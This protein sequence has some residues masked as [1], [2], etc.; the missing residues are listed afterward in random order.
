MIKEAMKKILSWFLSGVLI[1]SGFFVVLEKPVR[2]EW[3]NYVVISEF[4]TRGSTSAYDEFV[5]LYN[6]TENIVDISGWK[7]QY[8]GGSTWTTKLTI[9]SG[10]KI[11]PHRYYLMSSSSQYFT[12]TV[13]DLTH[14]SY[15]ALA[16]GTAGDPRGIRIITADNM[17]I[18][19][20]IYEADGGTDN[21]LAEG[22]KTAPAPNYRAN[23]YNRS[24]ERKPGGESGNGQDTNIN[25]HDFFVRD[26]RDPTNSQALPRPPIEQPPSSQPQCG[27]GT[28]ETGESSE[29]C[30]QDCQLNQPVCGNNLKE[31]KEECDKTDLAGQ[32]CMTLGF[33]SGTLSCNNNCTFN[34]SQCTS[35]GSYPPPIVEQVKPGDIA[36]NE[37]VSDPVDGEE[38]WIELYNNTDKEI[39][40]TN[41]QIEEGSGVRTT[42]SGTISSKSFFVVEKIK[43]YLNNSGDI[44]ILRGANGRIIDQVVYGSWDDGNREDNAPATKDP[45]S[46]ARVVDGQDTDRDYLDFKI[47]TL[48]TKNA[49]NKFEEEKEYPFGVIFNELLPNPKGDDSENEFIELK[50]LNDFE[51]NL[52]NWRLEDASG[53]KFV[54]SSQ[55]LSSTKI[56]GR[57]F[58]I[59]WR[60][61]SKI[62]LNNS[63]SER[64]KLYQPN[65]NLVDEISYSGT[66]AEDI[67]YAKEETKNWFLTTQPTPGQ[68]NIIKKVN[69]KPKAVISAPNKALV[70]EEIIFD[71]SDSYDPDGDG[72]TYLW[73]FGDQTRS[74][75]VVAKHFYKKTGKFNVKLE[76]KDS[77]GESEVVKLSL[78]ILPNEKKF[79]YSPLEAEIFISEFLPNPKG[80]DE[81]E[82]I[83]IFNN[84]DREVD[85]SGWFLD[86]MDGGSKPYQIKEGI[87]IL[88]G[89]HLLFE[90]KETKIA[91]NNNFDSVRILDPEGNLFFEVTYEKPKEG[92]SY[93]L[94][95]NSEWRWTSLLTPGQKNLFSSEEE[96]KTKK[97][98][99]KIAGEGEKFLETPLSEVRNQEIGDLVKTQGI[100]SVEPGILGKQIFYLAGSGI[101]IYSYQKDFPSLK[102]GDQIEVRGELAEYKNETRIKI[103]S[104]DDIKI[105]ESKTPPEPKKVKTGEVDESLEGNLVLIEGQLIE[106]RTNYFYL[107]DGSGE[108]KVYLKA[109]AGL[110]KPKM[111]EGNWLRVIGIVG[112]YGEEYRLYP[113]YQSDLEIIQKPEEDV[114]LTTASL[115]ETK[116]L[117]ERINPFSKSSQSEKIK[118]L[119]LSAL[120]LLIILISLLLRSR[121]KKY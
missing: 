86:D 82:W 6:P 120:T 14:N 35:G 37:F 98:S 20:I 121:R 79:S 66:V 63:G 70:N 57:G 105:L 56:P 111:K 10:T 30:P 25:G 27:N 4:A 97:S 22:G 52:E 39:D 95:E 47:S 65:D 16:D 94:D 17:V 106:S 89:E 9:P 88:P 61:D 87:K 34:T 108:V 116:P 67:A 72:L 109:T 28:C 96:I 115:S 42:L 49:P 71:A 44:I 64:V 12:T 53:T 91:L 36:I 21:S 1:F 110:K 68:E 73:D 50:N 80:R 45:N 18:D 43:G 107:D 74:N 5:E 90:R 15:L 48:P 38:E 113:R 76:V 62:A 46:V 41:W 118:Y 32:T 99:A 19:T 100:V 75:E 104:K 2:A 55:K 81:A 24:V 114:V 3:A 31:E 8:W 101:Q 102:L 26:Q 13:S 77:L 69:Q 83:E 23:T 92:F 119:S 112:Q 84:G 103:A 117:F 29:N 93:A 11:L 40:L 58:F 60:R 78:E 33:V 7:L 51:V 59:L 85:L 54:I